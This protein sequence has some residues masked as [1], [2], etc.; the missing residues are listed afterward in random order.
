LDFT[1]Q[2]IGRSHDLI[3]TGDGIRFVVRQQNGV[4]R[5]AFAIRYCSKVYGYINECAHIP[6]ELDWMEGAF[7][8]ANKK[9]IICS[10]H[11]AMFT[12]D[13]GKCVSGPCI[14]ASLQSINVFE[15][16]GYIYFLQNNE[17]FSSKE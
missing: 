15:E 12:P 14:G 11:G 7:F 2:I 1:K 17:K 10:N 5:S 8:D 13:E 6:V 3:E 9:N 16:N 4:D